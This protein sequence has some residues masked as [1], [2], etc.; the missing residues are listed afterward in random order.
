MYEKILEQALSISG[1]KRRYTFIK[2]DF[3]VSSSMKDFMTHAF[4]KLVMQE[5]LN[6]ANRLFGG[7]LL[8]W[9]DEA[10]VMCQLQTR[11]I[12]TVSLSEVVFKA[13]VKSGDFLEF[14]CQIVDTGR[15]SVK[16]AV[17]VKRKNV[18]DPED[19]QTVLSCSMSFVQLDDEGMRPTPHRFWKDK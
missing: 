19:H 7:R 16:V 2:L 15:T 8:Q 18:E 5:D 12:A 1:V 11:N 3:D 10:A 13:P 9:L 17:D 4:R 6:P 14:W